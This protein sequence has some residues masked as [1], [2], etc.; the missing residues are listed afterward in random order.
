L[1]NGK[2]QKDGTIGQ[3]V[4]EYPVLTWKLR[5]GATPSPCLLWK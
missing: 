5:D 3:P 4:E 1:Y 2:R